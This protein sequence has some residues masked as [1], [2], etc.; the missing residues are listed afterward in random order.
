MRTQL[1]TIST[2][3]DLDGLVA[4]VER[5]VTFDQPPTRRHL[6]TIDFPEL[7]GRGAWVIDLLGGGQRSRSLIQKG[8]Y[9]SIQS[10]TDSAI[11]FK[12]STNLASPFRTSKYCLEKGSLL[13]TR[14]DW[15]PFLSAL[16]PKSIDHSDR[17]PVCVAGTISPVGGRVYIEHRLFCRASKLI[18]RLEIGCRDAHE[19]QVQ[20]PVHLVQLS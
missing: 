18:G 17:W 2:A 19:T 5:T 7:K 14:K 3:I 12:L 9:R 16:I 10:L 6:E 8:Q 20:W 15:S 11:A 13:Q 4:N 1:D